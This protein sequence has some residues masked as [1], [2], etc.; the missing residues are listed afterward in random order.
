MRIATLL[1]I[2]AILFFVTTALRSDAIGPAEEM[3]IETSVVRVY[4]IY[5]CETRAGS[6]FLYPDVTHVVTALHVVGDCNSIR[7]SLAQN[8]GPN[9]WQVER[10]AQTS[11]I[12][13]SADLALLS[14]S[15][16][17]PAGHH[18][19]PLDTVCPTIR[20]GANVAGCMTEDHFALVGYEEL[21]PSSAEL[22]GECC[23]RATLQD[24]LAIK[25][26]NDLRSLGFPA[27]SLKILSFA[28]PILHGDSGAPILG[29]DGKV[30]GI[31]DGGFGEPGLEYRGWGI[32]SALIA[33]LPKSAEQVGPELA[34]LPG[35]FRADSSSTPLAG[36]LKVLVNW[37]GIDIPAVKQNGA[38]FIEV[39]RGGS[40]DPNVRK[41][42]SLL[43]GVITYDAST[44]EIETWK[45]F[46]QGALFVG[47]PQIIENG[48]SRP[49]DRP[50]LAYH[51]I[52][53]SPLRPIAE[54]SGAY[55]DWQG[56]QVNVR[57]ISGGAATFQYAFTPV[58]DSQQHLLR[59]T[60]WDTW[61][62]T[63]PGGAT[64]TWSAVGGKNTT[65]SINGLD[66][67]VLSTTGLW[68]FVPFRPSVANPSN[69]WLY[70][71]T[72]ADSGPWQPF[73]KITRRWTCH[74]LQIC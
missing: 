44:R 13:K 48:E 27:L 40:V 12:M 68:L 21:T 30:L 10:L 3:R 46:S 16:Q 20:A 35:E 28:S 43:D 54:I 5:P 56:D 31:A 36:R 63:G 60:N 64:K 51:D 41:L 25:E 9:E 34:K 32:P 24:I 26:Q 14:V 4:T 47:R 38:V 65:R 17:V 74:D 50:P 53:L 59:A 45:P 49:L 37:H 6:G 55:F 69:E 8:N 39:A 29:Q 1:V 71:S 11:K 23:A 67:F 22:I 66:G 52:I 19:L 62:E 61:I 42:F 72:V 18:P 2:L 70:F 73:T 58:D 7:V 15:G 57:Y 33:K